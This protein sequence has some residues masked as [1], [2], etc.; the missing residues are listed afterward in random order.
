MK[1]NLLIRLDFVIHFDQIFHAYDVKG[2]GRY[3]L[4][5]IATR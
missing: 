1:R 5:Q 2:K 3:D 4:E